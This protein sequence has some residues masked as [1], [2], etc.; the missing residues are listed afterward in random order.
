[1]DIIYDSLEAAA[2]MRKVGEKLGD[3]IAEYINMQKSR[4]QIA[5]SFQVIVYLLHL[6]LV[7]LAQFIVTLIQVLGELL[8]VAREL[9]VVVLP[10]AGATESIPGTAYVAVISLSMVVANAI[11]IKAVEG[12]YWGVIM[13]HFGI[14]ALISGVAITISS[15]FSDLL[16]RTFIEGIEAPQLSW[17]SFITVTLGGGFG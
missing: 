1:V 6:I 2:D 10:F 17:L 9:P 11:A 16:V 4:E 14:L 12:G 3:V 8:G 5:R 13:L 15:M 7:A